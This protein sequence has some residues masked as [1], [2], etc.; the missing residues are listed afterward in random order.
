[1]EVAPLELPETDDRDLKHDRDEAGYGET[2]Y[3]EAGYRELCGRAL[4]ALLLALASPLALAHVAFWPL[5]VFA[6]AMSVSALRR[7]R[8][9]SPDVSGR[10]LALSAMSLALIFG[11]SAPL[12]P[13][14][15]HY[16]MRAQAIAMAREW[17]HDLRDDKPQAAYQ[18][19]MA[20][21]LR[22]S[23][24]VSVEQYHARM[25]PR[26]GQK[27]YAEEPAVKLLS[28]LGKAAHVEFLKNLSVVTDANA[29]TDRVEDVYAVTDG[30][31]ADPTTALVKLTLTRRLDLMKRLRSWEVTKVELVRD[32]SKTGEA[33]L[34]PGGATA[35]EDEAWR[36]RLRRKLSQPR[37]PR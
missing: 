34:G 2:G 19:T 15:Y 23:A 22:H 32:P 35:D 12:Q 36:E 20:K 4:A 3:G 25:G 16:S 30:D 8:D 31:A 37:R 17:F 21:W 5:P 13:L 6:F 27:P 9:L 33:A 28:G 10:G 24:G 26:G 14:L 11:L 18:L 29:E 7:I 1:M